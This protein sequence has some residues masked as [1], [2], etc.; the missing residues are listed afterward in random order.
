[1]L[2]GESHELHPADGRKPSIV[3][4]PCEDP[5]PKGPKT[6]IVQTKRPEVTQ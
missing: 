2:T 4:V 3:V 1:M 5:P 6:K